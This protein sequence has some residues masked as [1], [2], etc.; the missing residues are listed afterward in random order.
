M[1]WRHGSPGVSCR[2][3]SDGG[4]KA[5]GNIAVA[6]QKATDI[7]SNQFLFDASEFDFIADHFIYTDHTQ[8]VTGS[9]GMSSDITWPDI[10]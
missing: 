3:R 4:F 5:Y 7:V 2:S 6:Q 8:I 1:T 10:H 9:G